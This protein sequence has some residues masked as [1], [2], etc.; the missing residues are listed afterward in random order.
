MACK[1]GGYV[2]VYMVFFSY[3]SL[4]DVVVD[5][6]GEDQIEEGFVS[7]ICLWVGSCWEE[8]GEEGGC[9]PPSVFIGTFH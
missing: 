2:S 1:T 5:K 8:W 6:L 3:S 4:R 9:L 7:F